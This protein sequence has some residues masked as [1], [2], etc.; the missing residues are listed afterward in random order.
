MRVPDGGARMMVRGRG[1]VSEL[2]HRR[3]RHRR[4]FGREWRRRRRIRVDL[5]M[6]IMWMRGGGEISAE[7]ALKRWFID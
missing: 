3:R 7:S 1:G 2:G 6:L 5:M 4:I